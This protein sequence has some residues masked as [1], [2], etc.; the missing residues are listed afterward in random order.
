MILLRLLQW[1]VVEMKNKRYDGF[2]TFGAVSCYM[3]FLACQDQ[4]RLLIYP[5][6]ADK[7][8]PRMLASHPSTAQT[9]ESILHIGK[10]NSATSVFFACRID[11]PLAARA[12]VSYWDCM[13]TVPYHT[14]QIA[15]SGTAGG[16]RSVRRSGRWRSA[17]SEQ[18]VTPD[19]QSAGGNQPMCANMAAER[20]KRCTRWHGSLPIRRLLGNFQAPDRRFAM[21]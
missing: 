6:R 14:A 7:P 4:D 3:R 12:P 16:A 1:N 17:F 2:G 20:I 10:Q 13:A 21:P 18:R 11:I 5:C 19:L 9:D 15:Q 8:P